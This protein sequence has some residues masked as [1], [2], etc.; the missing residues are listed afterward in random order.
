MKI[1]DPSRRLPEWVKPIFDQEVKQFS[2]SLISMKHILDLAYADSKD[3]AI[4]KLKELLDELGVP[5]LENFNALA[6]LMP[7]T[8]PVWV[9]AKATTLAA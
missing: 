5:K 3:A 1:A 9:I 4:K 7:K 2:E 8:I 6:N